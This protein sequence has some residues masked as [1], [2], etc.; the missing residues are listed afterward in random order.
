MDSLKLTDAMVDRLIE[1]ANMAFELN[2]R[3]FIELEDQN[4]D[5]VIKQYREREEAQEQEAFVVGAITPHPA[6]DGKADPALCPFNKLLGLDK[7]NK[8]E[9]KGEEQESSNGEVKHSSAPVP[10]LA[11]RVEKSAW[12]DNGQLL[13]K[14]GFVVLVLGVLGNLLVF[15]GRVPLLQ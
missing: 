2:I 7:L 5:E 8:Q 4:P 14:L 9:E 15:L 13:F 1:E 3:L 10:A 6:V 12:S 11:H